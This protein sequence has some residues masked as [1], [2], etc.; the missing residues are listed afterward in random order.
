MGQLLQNAEVERVAAAA[1]IELL[2]ALNEQGAIQFELL[3][4]LEDEITVV[5]ARTRYARS[6]LATLLGLRDELIRVNL[7]V[8]GFDPQPHGL[9][10]PFSERC[11]VGPTDHA[12]KLIIGQGLHRV[13]RQIGQR[14]SVNVQ[15][16]RFH[17]T[18]LAG[19]IVQPQRVA[20]EAD[21]FC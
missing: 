18:V 16:F 11:F 20:G 3:L 14:R 10:L 8:L 5:L 6:P 21:R 9:A 17:P 2:Q 19:F 12:G 4:Q 15:Q 1:R 13:A 7:C